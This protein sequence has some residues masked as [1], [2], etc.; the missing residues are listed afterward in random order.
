MPTNIENQ[1]CVTPE[2]YE[3]LYDRG[4]TTKIAKS[5]EN[6]FAY[7]TRNITFKTLE[8]TKACIH[9]CRYHI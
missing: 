9:T 4:G 7:Y 6:N 1:G 2:T 3:K 5:F 8:E